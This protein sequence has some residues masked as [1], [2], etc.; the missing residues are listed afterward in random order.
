MLDYNR[1]QQLEP[2]AVTHIRGGTFDLVVSSSS[3]AEQITECYVEPRLHVTSDHETILTRL[4]L[5]KPSWRKCQQEK[6][7]LDKIEEKKFVLSLEA[8]EDLI[9]AALAPARAAH[10]P[11][12]ST[13]IKQVLDKSAEVITKAIYPSLE[14]STERSKM[15]GKGEPWWN[16]DCRTCLQKMRKTQKHLAL[17]KAAGIINPNADAILQS[18]KADL[19]KIVKTAKQKYY[20][21]VIDGLDHQIIFQA[22]KWPSTV[23]QY[24]TPPIQRQDGSLAINSQDKQRALR[25]ALLT[26][27]TDAHQESPLEAPDL[28]KE[29]RHSPVEWHTC[30][31]HE[32]EAAIL[33]VG[34]TSAGPDGIP[35]LVIKKAWPVYQ[36]EITDLFQACLEIGYHP[37][38]FKN[39]TLCAL[40]KPGKRPRSLP[41]S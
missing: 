18:A 3:I 34:N 33:H 16:E 22:V 26:P 40:P 25:E 17:D 35:P 11:A 8:Q 41:R 30:T 2:G 21:K 5:G 36:K 27:P 6:F 14:L 20:Q 10:T 38:V 37:S 23:H 32:I 7:R 29:I 1:V 4:K 15:S 28:Q 9:Q 13:N 24:A 19:R 12:I 39:T 31:V